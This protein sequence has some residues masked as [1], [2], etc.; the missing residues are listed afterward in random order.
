ML[1]DGVRIEAKTASELATEVNGPGVYRVEVKLGGRPW[2]FSNPIYL[3][4]VER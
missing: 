2:V 4:D 3:R 1:R